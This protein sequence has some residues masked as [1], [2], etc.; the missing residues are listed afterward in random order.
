[1][2]IT[3]ALILLVGLSA[4]VVT[5]PSSAS[6]TLAVSAS[7]AVRSHGSIDV[8]IEKVHLHRW[9]GVHRGY[10]AYGY[11]HRYYYVPYL[12]PCR[13]FYWPFPL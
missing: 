7:W 12:C 4:L 9:R 10:Y 1:M 6:S 11:P 8:L 5:I 3:I 2:R 13:Y